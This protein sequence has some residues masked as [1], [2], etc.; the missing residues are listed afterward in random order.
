MRMDG[1]DLFA[2]YGCTLLEGSFDTLLKY[3]KRKAVKYRNWAEADGIDP[4]LS[5]VE[6]EPRKVKLSFLMESEGEAGFWRQYRRLTADLSAPGYRSF[7]L[8]PGLTTRLRLDTGALF[9]L[10]VPLN[11][12]RNASSFDLNF[13][14]DALLIT[15]A[16]YPVGGITLRGQM[17]INGI[18]FGAF[19]IGSDDELEDILKTPA[20][21]TPF[22]D[23]RTVDLSTIKV[24]HREVKLSLWML[25][26]SPEEFLNNY[27]A[28]FTQLTGTGT[29]E[30][31]IKT[32]ES[33]LQVYYSDCPSY[34]VETWRKDSVAVR[35]TLSLVIPVISWVDAGG[36]VRYTVLVDRGLGILADEE[37]RIIVFN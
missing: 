24:Q 16:A 36:D 31:Y 32:L 27:R 33:T 23:G 9:E 29:Q 22:T 17:A 26:G 10:P 3:P 18:D 2:T 28:F 7:D 6:F 21:K 11:S 35:F 25:A 5:V 1:K 4:D 15:P 13:V 8:L 37:G 14:E 19:G 34:S 30:L 20:M 12:G